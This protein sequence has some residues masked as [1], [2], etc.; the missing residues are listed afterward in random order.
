[1]EM[2]GSNTSEK[3]IVTRRGT[4]G[5]V[6]V[7]LPMPVKMSMMSWMRKS[8]MGKAEFFRVSLMMGAA[9]LADQVYAKQPNEGY[10]NNIEEV[11]NNE[12]ATART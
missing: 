3:I 7:T 10:H 6:Q 11:I 9:R 12:Q 1:M 2:E 4:Y 8:G 5:R